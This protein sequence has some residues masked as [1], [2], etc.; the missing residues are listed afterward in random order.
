MT[1]MAAAAP[2][3]RT[4][5]M[6][7]VIEKT[8]VRRSDRRAW[9]KAMGNMRP[10]VYL[11][12]HQQRR[13]ADSNK[14]APLVKLYRTGVDVRFDPRAQLPSRELLGGP[15]QSPA[16]PAPLSVFANRNPAKYRTS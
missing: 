6:I 4:S 5:V 3:P 9:R 11:L 2:I 14:P 15:E 1:N 8:G 12:D 13:L 10:L 16:V 7:A